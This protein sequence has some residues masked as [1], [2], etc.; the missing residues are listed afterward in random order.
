MD[1]DIKLL[2][3]FK[4]KVDSTL[5]KD[6]F[7]PVIAILTIVKDGTVKEDA[8]AELAGLCSK[9]CHM[10]ETVDDLAG[11]DERIENLGRIVSDIESAVR[12]RANCV[13]A[14]PEHPQMPTEEC[15]NKWRKELNGILSF[16]DGFSRRGSSLELSAIPEHVQETVDS[17]PEVDQ[18]PTPLL[19]LASPVALGSSNSSPDERSDEPA[20]IYSAVPGLHQQGDVNHIS[21]PPLGPTSE[22][23]QRALQRLVSPG[24]LPNELASFIETVAL[25]IKAADI[26]QCLRGTDAQ[27]F[28]NVID[29]SL[30]TIEFTPPV[31]RKCVKSLYK[32][33]AGHTLLPRSLHL[34]LP[35][36]TM[37]DVQYRSGSADVL[38]CERSDGAVAVKALRPRDGVSLEDMT[39]RFCKELITWKSLQH[40]NVLPLQGAI[41]TGGQFAMVSEWMADG[42]IKEFIA[43]RQDANRFELLAD[44][45][46][47]LMH[48][49]S[50]GMIHGDLKGANILIDKNGHAC[51]AD[52]GLLTI[53]SD[54][55]NITSSNSFLTGGSYR[56]MNRYA[57]GMVTYEVLSGQYPFSTHYGYAVVVKVLK[58]RRPARP[59]G[60]EGRWFT[61][62]IWSILECCWK[63]GPDDRP[64]VKAVLRCLEEVSSTWTPPQPTA[65]F[66]T[67]IPP[68]RTM[69]S[70]SEGTTDE[71]EIP[72]SQKVLP[73]PSP[74]L[75]L[76]ALPNDASGQRALGTAVN[77]PSGESERIMDR[78][79]PVG[80]FDGINLTAR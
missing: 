36:G 11:C 17:G 42:N 69:E 51:L 72:A 43:A 70:S 10:L 75:R 47:G 74:R 6:V 1:A 64:K 71:D 45:A 80:L 62:D 2:A 52:F 59:E 65:D 15:V 21:E 25:N 20:P 73:Q 12:T 27:I 26:V 78:V 13:V 77:Y 39:N 55:T 7:E 37:G 31:R 61:D 32:M 57:F 22:A 9:T 14:S 54:A 79:C 53:A 33:C 50:R 35:G 76:E 68:R 24:V 30:E 4:D 28:I 46:R 41:M 23:V 49:H 67:V 66:P 3:N 8:F 29:Q 48:L 18:V 63:A 16:F 60:A 34:E 44:A 40:P 38:R 5:V 58:G 56:W 19:T